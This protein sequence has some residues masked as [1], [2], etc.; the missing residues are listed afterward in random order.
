MR[1]LSFLSLRTA[2]ERRF[3]DNIRALNNIYISIRCHIFDYYFQNKP[4]VFES[5]KADYLYHF[6][7]F[8]QEINGDNG[9]LISHSI[10]AITWNGH[11][12]NFLEAIIDDLHRLLDKFAEK[13]SPHFNNFPN[14]QRTILNENARGLSQLNAFEGYIEVLEEKILL[15]KLVCVMYT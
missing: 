2:Q 8:R 4:D 1:Y 3:W 15:L 9:E 13:F 5:L 10:A 7:S 11:Y 6:T 12:Q 14:F